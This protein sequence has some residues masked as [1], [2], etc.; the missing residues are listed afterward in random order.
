MQLRSRA[1]WITEKSAWIGAPAQRDEVWYIYRSRELQG[2]GDYV[3]ENLP[4][5]FRVRSK[6]ADVKARKSVLQLV[7]DQGQKVLVYVVS[8]NGGTGLLA[9]IRSGDTMKEQM[10][11]RT[12]ASKD[13]S[14]WV[15]GILEEL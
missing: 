6:L 4:K 11:R 15:N 3:S 12:L 2:I 8:T 10:F 5:G 9:R 7:S 1:Y 13:V 14:E